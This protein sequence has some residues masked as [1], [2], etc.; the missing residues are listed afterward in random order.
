MSL[1]QDAKSP[2]FH[3]EDNE[4]GG[5][6]NDLTVQEK[7]E[8][9]R[10]LRNKLDRRIVPSAAFIYLLC[11]LDR[12][13]IG[14][15]KLL[16]TN[17]GDSLM[18]SLSLTNLQY[19]IA[20]MVFLIA[21]ISFEVPSN[22]CLKRFTPSR[23]IAF[24]MFSW[25]ALTIS[26]GGVHSYG[27][28]TAVRFLLG[29]FEAGLFPGLVYFF[30]FWYRPEER[31]LRVALVLASSTLAGAFGGA[32][33]YGVGFMN[34]TA[35]LEAWRWLFIL[36]G[37]PSVLSSVVVW[38][39]FPDFPETAKWLSADERNQVIQRLEGVASTHH[40]RV[41][42]TEAK[43]TLLGWRVWVH[44]IAYITISVPFSSLS[45]FSPTIVAGLGY[46]G[47]D[48][49]LFTVPPYACAYFVTLFLSWFADTK[50]Q[51]SL[52]SACSM[53]VGAFA[54]LAQALLPENAFKARFGFLCV[55][56]SGSFGSIRWLST[57][58]RG[59]G[60]VGLAIAVNISMGGTGQ[61]IGVWIYKA[62]EKPGYITGILR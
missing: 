31:S 59:A 8:A 2:A 45:L 26:L 43:Q 54:F 58:V 18:Q 38:F 57:N 16:N 29:T 37:I 34:M 23:W 39:F 4:K 50:N 11:Y 13:N 52:V 35:G 49:Q 14:N 41:T 60:A 19:T 7:R 62:N 6:A 53:A 51:R 48:A 12:S 25:G 30:T 15:A 5:S 27:A 28:L 20:L 22:Y 17:S 56:A 61:I 47:L 46:E 24:L 44:A 1:S 55:A 36:E 21:Y 40:S 3:I 42:W 9:D 10:K 32:I 33:A